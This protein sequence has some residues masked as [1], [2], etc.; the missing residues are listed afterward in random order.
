MCFLGYPF[1]IK[2]YK[3]LDL[4]SKRIFILRDVTFHES[5]FPFQSILK[6]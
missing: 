5:M 4:H 2:G 1:T 3:L 6:A